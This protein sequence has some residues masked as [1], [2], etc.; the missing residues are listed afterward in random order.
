MRLDICR[1]LELAIPLIDKYFEESLAR[2]QGHGMKMFIEALFVIAE[3][4]NSLNGH[5]QKNG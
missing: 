5:Q 4:C 1:P 2:T 3:T